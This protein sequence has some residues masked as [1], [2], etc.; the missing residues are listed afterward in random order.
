MAR[1]PALHYCLSTKNVMR[2]GSK[3][4]TCV[5]FRPVLR[6]IRKKR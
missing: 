1:G 4:A 3:A 6:T 2:D 5:W